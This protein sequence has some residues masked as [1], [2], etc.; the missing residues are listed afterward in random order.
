MGADMHGG[1]ETVDT[2][3]I[4]DDEGKKHDSKN[5]YTFCDLHVDRDYTLFALI[6]GVRASWQ[7]TQ[8]RK[9]GTPKG[10]PADAGWSMLE[11]YA[12][13]VSDSF[14]GEGRCS[15]GDA[16]RWINQ[17]I[18]KVIEERDGK[19]FRINNPDWHSATWLG[20]DELKAIQQSYNSIA[21]PESSWYQSAS[22]PIPPG[23][24][25][26]DSHGAMRGEVYVESDNKMPIY[27]RQLNAWI[28]MMEALKSDTCE[29]RLVCWFDN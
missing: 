23:H 29:P 10:F 7:N 28:A 24:H 17:G 15:F 4:T 6:A 8:G 9:P 22:A 19:P 3:T 26:A 21:A 18:S 1:I 2:F 20:L 14:E 13:V 25:K 27:S 5:V 12:L 16:E 11:R